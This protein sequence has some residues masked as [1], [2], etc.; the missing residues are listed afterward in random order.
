MP[1]LIL[2]LVVHPARMAARQGGALRHRARPAGGELP[3]RDPAR[4][5]RRIPARRR[6]RSR[7]RPSIFGAA[8]LLAGDPRLAG[9]GLQQPGPHLHHR[10]PRARGAVRAEGDGRAADARLRRVF[11]A[12]HRQRGH[13]L[14]PQRPHPGRRAPRS[15]GAIRH[16]HVRGADRARP[17]QHRRRHRAPELPHHPRGLVF[18]LALAF[19]LGGKEWAAELLERWWPRKRR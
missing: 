16:R 5:P 8:G 6:H 3:H 17:G 11:R 9:G 15:A 10:P 18:A 4:G 19:G 13:R 7:H 2:A 1:R 14:L 12:L